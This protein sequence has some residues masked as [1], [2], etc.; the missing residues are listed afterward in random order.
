MAGL[1][2]CAGAGRPAAE[3][4]G[5]DDDGDD[6]GGEGKAGRDDGGPG[7]PAVHQIVE[8]AEGEHE[9]AADHERPDPQTRPRSAAGDHEDQ[10]GDCRQNGAEHRS[11]E[12]PGGEVG[13]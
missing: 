8:Q 13:P 10:P 2:R 9:Q 4:G 11:G 3:P 12:Q 6:H 1:R 5:S 7:V